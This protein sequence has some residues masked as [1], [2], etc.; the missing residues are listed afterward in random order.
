MI[1]HS[2]GA[3]LLQIQDVSLEYN[4][5]LVLKGVNAE[6]KDVIVP[7]RITGQVV[8]FIGPSG[9]GKSSL[10]RIMAGLEQPTS[11]RVILSGAGH[12]VKAGEVGVVAQNYPLFEHRTVLSNLMLA[13]SRK[14]DESPKEAH[15]RVVAFLNEFDLY[16]QINHYP[17]QLSGGQRQ[18][19]AILQ[20]IL[21]S[22]HFILMDEPFSGLDPIMKGRTQDLILKIANM[23]ELNTIII[24][25][26]DIA[27]ASA[28][29]DHL[30]LM[31]RDRDTDGKVIP[32]ARIVQTYNLIERD[33]AWRPDL[34]TD[35]RFAEFVVE[36]DEL[37]KT[38]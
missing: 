26:H 15:E 28:V 7:G 36:M 10:F 1:P 8:G 22:D 17:M 38:L 20:Q 25:S 30:W 34:R 13:A 29:S 32:G 19:C 23:N 14:H 27:A 4:G 12:P 16:E 37:F 31:G 5:K 35:P 33:L 3:T 6:I 2:Y 18:R 11:G 9:I 21:C 24:V